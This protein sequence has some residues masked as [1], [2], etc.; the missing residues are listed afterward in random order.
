MRVCRSKNSGS[1]DSFDG[2]SADE[3]DPPALTEAD[4]PE[5]PEDPGEEEEDG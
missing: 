1:P 5:T 4:D 2:Y 3:V